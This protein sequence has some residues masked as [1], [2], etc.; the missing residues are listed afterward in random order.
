MTFG[1][2]M[3]HL[4]AVSTV[5]F[6]GFSVLVV[7][8]LHAQ[9]PTADVATVADIVRATY[10]VISGPAGTPRQWQRASALY[11]PGATLVGLREQDGRLQTTIMTPDDYRRRVDSAMV[12]GGFFETEV[13]SRIERYG[14]VARVRSVCVARRTP[15]GPIVARFVNYVNLYSDGGRWWIASQVW[16]REG[17]STPIAPDW[18]GRWEDVG[19]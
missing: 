13:G 4:R 15:E 14:H 12:A 19:Q 11:M 7:A 5:F 1:E 16:E 8:Q 18:I 17:P 3:T 2:A 9:A 10:E 6:A